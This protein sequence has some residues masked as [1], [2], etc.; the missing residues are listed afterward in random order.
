MF[1]AYPLLRA[2]LFQLPPETAHHLT[3]Q[4]MKGLE[5]WPSSLHGS[6]AEAKFHKKMMGLEVSNPLGLAAGLDKN[7]E[8]LKVWDKL[9]FG[10]IE[11]GTVT[12]LPQ[13]GNPKP[14]MFRLVQ[15]TALINRLGFNNLGVDNLVENIRNYKGQ[16]LLGVNIGKNKDTPNE[17]ADEDY[18]KCF[19]MVAPYA[20]YITIN[21]SSPNTPGL[22]ELQ[23]ADYLNAL[24]EKLK[25]AQ[26]KYSSAKKPLPI[27]VKIAPDIELN[28]L[29]EML[30]SF[31]AY[32]IEGVIATNTTIARNLN[33]KAPEQNEQGG[34]SG[35]PLL[36]KSNHILSHIKANVGNRMT[37]IGVGGI[38][39]GI[40]AQKKLDSGA[41]FLQIYTGF[42]YR[43]PKLIEEI[44]REISAGKS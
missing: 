17:K 13:I 19:H 40:S 37:L 33:L 9:G 25:E 27:C 10:F 21:I 26:S 1:S 31:L 41:D 28:D 30:N 35:A 12:P 43:G 7:G 6:T 36:E 24:L 34:L 44:L 39:D 22:R 2:L 18:L 16:A 29:E 15:D 11:V 8:L 3:F 42:I 38:T 14:R 4:L 5:W 32:K 23:K 20:D